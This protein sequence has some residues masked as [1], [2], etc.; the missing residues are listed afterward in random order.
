MLP[1]VGSLHGAEKLIRLIGIHPVRSGEAHRGR[2]VRAELFR[3]L[4]GAPRQFV[5]I[6]H[7]DR[8]ILGIDAKGIRRIVAGLLEAIET[9]AEI[10]HLAFQ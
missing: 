4:V 8:K 10:A 2:G 5:E 1:L 9:H 6:R 7:D 3:R